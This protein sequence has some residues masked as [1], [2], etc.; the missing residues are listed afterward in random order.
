[1]CPADKREEVAMDQESKNI[2]RRSDE[3]T[4]AEQSADMK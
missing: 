1:M 3:D 4:L 2:K